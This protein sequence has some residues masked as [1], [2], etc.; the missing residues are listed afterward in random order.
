MS[1]TFTA[2]IETAGRSIDALGVAVIVGGAAVAAI[3]TVRHRHRG[4][5][6]GYRY[7]PQ[8]L[9]RSILLGLELLVAR[10]SFGPWR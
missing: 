8:Q 7:F 4:N 9:G 1:W 10:I 5:L 2:V 3:A 6:V